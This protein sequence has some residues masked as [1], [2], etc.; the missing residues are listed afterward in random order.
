MPR[1]GNRRVGLCPHCAASK[2]SGGNPPSTLRNPGRY[3]W[4]AL[5]KPAAAW[6]LEV[7]MTVNAL[8]GKA[9]SYYW[10]NFLSFTDARPAPGAKLT[11]DATAYFGLQNWGPG[12]TRA[13]LFSLWNGASGKPDPKLSQ[14]FQA[15]GRDRRAWCAQYTHEGSGTQCFAVMDWQVGVPYKF[16]LALV[17]RSAAGDTLR[18]TLTNTKTGASWLLG[19]TFVRAYYGRWA[20]RGLWFCC[21]MR[22]K[23]AA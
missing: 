17:G 12:G 13:A 7:T 1:P 3:S 8:Q 4:P 10:S 14:Q 2:A 20:P 23:P 16:K 21:M 9:T 18:C 15:N 11:D 5:P 22:D 19:E 6:T